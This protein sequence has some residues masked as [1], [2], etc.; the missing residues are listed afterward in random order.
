[1]EPQRPIEKALRQLAAKRQAEQGAQFELH[2]ATRRLLQGEVSRQYPHREKRQSGAWRE[3]LFGSFWLR[4]AWSASFVAVLGLFMALETLRRPD[5]LQLA[6][7]VP[8]AGDHKNWKDTLSK[9]DE[10]PSSGNSSETK[11]TALLGPSGKS[12]DLG[13]EAPALEP[14]ARK[15]EPV[16]SNGFKR[17]VSP[18]ASSA[19]ADKQDSFELSTRG[20]DRQSGLDALAAKTVTAGSGPAQAP[21]GAV[22][23]APLFKTQS[24]PNRRKVEP[25]RPVGQVEQL[26]DSVGKALQNSQQFVSER[27]RDKKT[28]EEEQAIL[29]QF[30]FSQQGSQLR[31]Q[32]VDGS[33]YS[34]EVVPESYSPTN[35]KAGMAS[36]RTTQTPGAA[37]RLSGGNSNAHADQFYFQ[38]SGTNRSSNRRVIFRGR[39]ETSNEITS[40]PAGANRSGAL[41]LGGAS[42]SNSSQISERQ[43]RNVANQRQLDLRNSRISGTAEIEGA[44]NEEIRAVPAR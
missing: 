32:D 24:S 3:K 18:L 26:S 35:N 40:G 29:D 43:Y 22:A 7:V 38:V 36:R 4:A 42:D 10:K 6:S 23:E 9:A 25:E 34:G 27:A 39:L 1:M 33:V 8:E 12:L 2:P 41:G 37:A 13:N 11:S 14:V 5:S 44:K 17:A 16:D 30:N 21:Q 19:A 20:P 28:R 15:R 31:V